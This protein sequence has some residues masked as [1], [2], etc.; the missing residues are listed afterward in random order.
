MAP[1]PQRIV[2]LFHHAPNEA[3]VTSKKM[4]RIHEN[5]SV[6]MVHDFLTE[7]ELDYL[8]RT[9]TQHEDSFT[10]SFIE[11]DSGEREVSDN[12]LHAVSF[13]CRRR[14][15]PACRQIV[16]ERTSTYIFLD[17]GRDSTVRA[18]EARA[19]DLI[20]LRCARPLTL[21]VVRRGL[22]PHHPVVPT[23]VFVPTR[24][25]CTARTS[26]SRCRS[27]RTRRGKN[28]SCTTTPGR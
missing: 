19:A 4:E 15:L 6:Y 23:P 3:P 27:C 5:P 26:W 25:N 28:S 20:S 24:Y 8:D 22:V 18:I 17:K 2:S 11:N 1:I 16:E 9:V 13:T 14:V 7:A 10:A 21:S 12:A